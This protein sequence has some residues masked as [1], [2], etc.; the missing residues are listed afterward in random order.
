[1]RKII[2]SNQKN[3]RDLGGLIGFE[4]KKVKSGRLY[5]GGVLSS[6]IV[7]EEDIKIIDSLHLTDI[8]DFRSEIEFA[9]RHDYP[10]EG[11]TFHNFVAMINDIKKDDNKHEDSNLLWFLKDDLDG[12]K[13]MYEI[14]PKI[15]VDPVGIA[16]YQKFFELLVSKDDGVF[17]FHC[18]QGKDRAGLAAYFL[19]MALGVSKEQAFE[20]YMMSNEAME[21]RLAR[22][23]KMVENE[24]FYNEK[25]SKAMDEVFAVDPRYLNHAL[26][27]IEET[28]GS[29]D[30]Y[31]RNVLK[32]D[33]E[34]LRKLYLE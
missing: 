27:V 32:I 24:P 17:Y 30:N 22:L 21:I 3:I 4:G 13:H 8:I 23:K 15:T 11:V 5:R 7:N 10:F 16:A 25:Y 6:H 28:F 9:N 18:S 29:M 20:D 26:E 1:M 31:L 33:I 2:L 12:F 34:K 14:Y 19:E